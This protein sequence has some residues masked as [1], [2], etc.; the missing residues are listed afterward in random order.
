MLS[1]APAD[2]PRAQPGCAAPGSAG[3]RQTPMR[4]SGSGLTPA[5]HHASMD[6]EQVNAIGTLLADLSA[7]TE[8]LRGYL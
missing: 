1:K 3:A 8:Q 7:R 5:R 4:E 2:L 6:I